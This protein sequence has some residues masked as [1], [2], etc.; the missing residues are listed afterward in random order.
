[1]KDT[2]EYIRHDYGARND[3]KLMR[4]QMEMKGQGLAI[5]WCLVEMLWENDGYMPFNPK[6]IAYTLRW[7]TEKEVTRVISDYNLFEHDD[8]RFWSASALER[9]KVRTEARDKWKEAHSRASKARWGKRE[10]SDSNA[11]AMQP[12][13]DSNADAMRNDA[14]VR[15]GKVR[16]GKDKYVSMSKDTD[17]DTQTQKN[18]FLKIFF[19][20][21]NVKNPA[22][23]LDRF[24]SHYEARGWNFADG[25]PVVDREAAAAKW[26]VSPENKGPRF[27]QTFLRWYKELIDGIEAECGQ[28]PAGLLLDLVG[29][30]NLS[31]GV[32]RLRYN[33][34]AGVWLWKYLQEHGLD[35]GVEI[36]QV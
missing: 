32:I 14:K 16:L 36:A 1:M 20:R 12:E 29:V 27:N 21:K 5:F 23:E 15:L 30:E 9:I 35:R 18:S 17:D 3:P 25:Q 4:L 2:A 24:L 7:A 19:F 33:S 13:S 10:Q 8:E 26:T 28:F 6:S 22:F 31:G 11:D 34:A